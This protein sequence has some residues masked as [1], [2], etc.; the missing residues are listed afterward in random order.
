MI[1]TGKN[2]GRTALEV[3]KRDGKVKTFDETVEAKF[4]ALI[5]QDRFQEAE[6]FIGVEL[7][8]K[9][10]FLYGDA[11]H[12]PGWG[13]VTGK[14]FGQF[15]TF[16]VQY[17]AQVTESLT[18][19]TVKDRAEFLVVH[20]AINLGIISA[21]AKLFDADLTSW[22]FL[23]SLTYTGG[24]YAD[25]LINMVGAIGGGDA[26]R[27]IALRNLQLKLPSWNSPSIFI[28]GSYFIGDVFRGFEEDSFVKGVFRASGIRF[29]EGRPTGTERGLKFGQD[30]VD[31]GFGWLNELNPLP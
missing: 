14:L 18:R 7:A 15:G 12:P 24:P 1:Q 21:G 27:A 10:F 9:V 4:E 13:G 8:N 28:P 26:E 17:L 16:P 23:P 31:A 19:G 5:R 22:A 11:N 6:D 20:S 2:K 3:L 25:V 29:L 30:V